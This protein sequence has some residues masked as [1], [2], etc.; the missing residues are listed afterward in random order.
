[1][2]KA[3]IRVGGHYTARV[4]GKYVTVRVD[5]IRQIDEGY[6][7][8]PLTTKSPV[9]TVYD[10]TNLATGRKTTF[11][12][13]AKFRSEVEKNT[14]DGMLNAANVCTCGKQKPTDAETCTAC[15][16]AALC[17]KDR[18]DRTNQPAPSYPAVSASATECPNCGAEIDPD[19]TSTRCSEC[20][21]NIKEGEQ[22]AD[23]TLSLPTTSST[24]PVTGVEQTLPVPNNIMKDAGCEK[25]TSLAS[26]IAQQA[27]HTTTTNGVK[28]TTQQEEILVVAKQIEA[29]RDGGQRVFVLGA[30]AGTGKTFELK[31]LEQILL[32]IGQYNAFSRP[33]VDEAREKFTKARCDT[34]HG[35]AF[36]AV[37]H[38]FA[39]RLKAARVRSY[40][41][42]HRLGIKDFEYAGTP[43]PEGSAEWR[44]AYNAAGYSEENP[45]PADFRPCPMKRLRA[46]FL[47]GQITE[48]IKR[49]CQSADSKISP[50]HF[51]QIGG[52]DEAGV[53]ENNNRVKAYLQPFAEKAWADLSSVDGTLPF[54]HDVYVK[55][56]QLGTGADR[57]V[58]AADYILL[59]E[60]QDTAEV[61][62]DV[63]KQQTAHAM[64]I[65]VGDDN[66]QIY[67]WRGAVNAMAAFSGAPRRLLSQSF[68]FG[69]TVADV[70]NSVLRTL[71]TPT[72]LVMS[73]LE[74]IPTRVCA[75]A[76]PR[77]YLYR[78]NAGAVSKLMQARKENKRGHLIGGTKEVVAF[79]QAAMDLK[80]GLGT[81]HQELGCFQKWEEV[82][83]YAKEDEGADLRLMVKLIDDFGA[84]EIRDALKHM[85]EEAKADLILSTAHRSKGR[86]WASVKLGHD[87]PLA[88]KMSDA[89]RRL[90]Y[91][92]ATRAQEELDITEC[93]TFCGG[94]DK[95]GGGEAEWVPGISIT[96]TVPMP[97]PEA[98]AEY[99]A[100][101]SAPKPPV[102]TEQP[103]KAT[104]PTPAP[105][106][107]PSPIPALANGNGAT[108]EFTWANM[109]DKWC[110]R[111]PQNQ[112]IGSKVTVT[113]KNGTTSQV[114]LGKVV[115]KLS[116]KWF[117][118]V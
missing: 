113:R 86:E 49:F 35:L 74:T 32:G 78:T 88:N 52:I 55:I 90:V 66:Q 102:A 5:A 14:P 118:E 37:G 60:A 107:A 57:P 59:D 33:L 100:A 29:M 117:Y 46:G 21:H 64:L 22:S 44:D 36:R 69:Q 54:Q 56:W 112:A 83:E 27:N 26:K 9:I 85:P 24:T 106:A 48:A 92:A 15:L 103:A 41:I 38:K 3:E 17:P 67:E 75:V 95:K 62:L 80:T 73:G 43:Y 7:R 18:I 99:R 53:Y 30:G 31:Q 109:D 39:H 96:Y 68:R 50:K 42:A 11:R 71:D 23:P 40:E 12:S 111:G 45:P 58:I 28:L 97:T 16:V 47:A 10:V 72:D 115:R 6:R 94:L 84:E 82:Q 63:L 70:A 91:V 108:G 89:D 105:I 2:K 79:C 98:L 101:K 114:T 51:Q 20:G 65:M 25:I 116:D 61:F 1:M 87:F 8:E 13:A 93:P 77:C 81:T 19:A 110:V 4:S 76:E 34:Q 104:N